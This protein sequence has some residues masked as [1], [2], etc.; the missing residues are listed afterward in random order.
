[1]WSRALNV[2][3][4]CPFCSISKICFVLADFIWTLWVE[5]E[6]VAVPWCLEVCVG[7]IPQ[8]DRVQSSPAEQLQPENRDKQCVQ[9]KGSSWTWQ[10]QQLD[11]AQLSLQTLQGCFGHH[12]QRPRCP[13]WL[14]LQAWVRKP[15]FSPQSSVP[16]AVLQ[17]CGWV[18]T[19]IQARAEIR[20]GMEGEQRDQFAALSGRK[21]RELHFLLS[22]MDQSTTLPTQL[23]K[24]GQRNPWIPRMELHSLAWMFSLSAGLWPVR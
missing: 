15:E 13:S 24:K 8:C 2:F 3:C 9:E 19:E 12:T 18:L 7:C 10:S 22:T 16:E 1:M 4:P 17:K 14:S 20:E 23:W 5:L 6:K 21:S 11:P